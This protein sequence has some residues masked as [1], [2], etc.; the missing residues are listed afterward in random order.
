M[1]GLPIPKPPAIT[2]PL[3]SGPQQAE[4][5]RP[6]SNSQ[7]ALD[8]GQ[9]HRPNPTSGPPPEAVRAQTAPPRQRA[10]S[11]AGPLDSGELPLASL[12]NPWPVRILI[13]LAV[14][15]LVGGV[16]AY[17]IT[18][19]PSNGGSSDPNDSALATTDAAVTSP[20]IDATSSVATV[21]AVDA[22]S[23]TID[24]AQTDSKDE[25]DA[26]V[27]GASNPGNG[28][29]KK[30]GREPLM[31]ARQADDPEDN[32]ANVRICIDR[33]GAVQ[34]VRVNSSVSDVTRSEIA[35]AVGRWSFEPYRR[36]YKPV[37]A[38]FKRPI[39]LR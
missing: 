21:A 17:L 31:L 9:P 23:Q 37:T 39:R 10:F 28:P 32:T 18:S 25:T 11:S 2:P 13:G 6:Q 8:Q 38:C 15:S 4:I 20:T 7:A 26:S 3:A 35:A 34:S 19:M 14:L 30:S 16:G 27:R 1:L 24:S 29:R 36:D 22:A 5:P 33:R 12:A